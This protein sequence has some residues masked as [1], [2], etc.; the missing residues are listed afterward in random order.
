LIEPASNRTVGEFEV[1]KD[2]SSGGLY[3]GTARVED[4][5][6]RSVAAIF[7]TT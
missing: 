5:F 1:S 7:K 6:A 2:F 3:G 4:G